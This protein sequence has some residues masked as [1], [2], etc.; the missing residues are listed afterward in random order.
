MQYLAVDPSSPPSSLLHLKARLRPRIDLSLVLHML[1]GYATD[2]EKQ[3]QR[4][5]RKKPI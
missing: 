4:Y 3:V 5:S 2:K 1:F